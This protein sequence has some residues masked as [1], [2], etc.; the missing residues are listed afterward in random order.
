MLAEFIEFLDQ[1]YHG[2][3][4]QDFREENPQEFYR[5]LA[6]FSKQHSKNEIRN[7]FYHGSCGSPRR[8]YQYRKNRQRNRKSV[9]NQHD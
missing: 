8:S 9:K 7:P 5:Q 2:G 4:G 6:E 3:Y 1:I